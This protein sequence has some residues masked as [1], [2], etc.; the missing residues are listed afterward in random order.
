[1][2]WQDEMTEYIKRLRT[3]KPHMPIPAQVGYFLGNGVGMVGTLLASIPGMSEF[4]DG[5]KLGTFNVQA[6]NAVR[7]FVR[8]AN[9]ATEEQLRQ[10]ATGNPQI[11]PAAA[12]A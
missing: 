12:S 8:A 9:K 1:M 5:F 11:A 2:T 6:Q 7:G 10:M 3:T 4:A